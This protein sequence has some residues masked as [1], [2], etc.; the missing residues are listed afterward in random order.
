MHKLKLDL[1]QLTVDSFDTNPPAGERRGTVQGLARTLY[2]TC[3]CSGGGTCISC[4]PGCDNSVGG[5]CDVS[6]GGTCDNTCNCT[7][8]SCYGTCN[9]SCNVTC[10]TCQT[11]CQQESCVYICP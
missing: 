11:N 1:D 6:C 8:N 2:D 3:L 5:T 9:V 10:D 7:G 4:D